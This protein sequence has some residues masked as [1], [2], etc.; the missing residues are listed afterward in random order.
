MRLSKAVKPSDRF[1]DF[2]AISASIR[3]STVS[4]DC[5]L[6]AVGGNISPSKCQCRCCIY[7][8]W[9]NHRKNFWSYP[10]GPLPPTELRGG[11]INAK[12]TDGHRGKGVRGVG[13]NSDKRS[14]DDMAGGGTTIRERP[15]F[16][17][18]QISSTVVTYCTTAKLVLV[19]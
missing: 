4:L 19:L 11:G 10:V 18:R 2:Y 17:V 7:A 1:F 12:R 15:R 16:Q 9:A 8:T 5:R 13:E 6:C 14:K 3:F